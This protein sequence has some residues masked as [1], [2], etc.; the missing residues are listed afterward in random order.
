M[1][2]DLNRR[3]LLAG[4]ALLPATFSAG[5]PNTGPCEADLGFDRL[6]RPTVR[7]ADSGRWTLAER[8][9]HHH[10]PA[11]AVAILRDGRLHHVRGLGRLAAGASAAA[12]PSTLFSV[13][14]VSKVATAA[15]CLRLVSLGHLDL[16]RD[17]G[18][19]LRRW[20]L[21]PG[22]AGDDAPVTIRMLLSHTAGLNVHGFA[23]FPPGAELPTL[24]Q[25]LAGA[26]PARNRPIA[27]IGRA[28]ER[29]RYSGG[30]YMVVQAVLEDAMGLAFERLAAD[31]LFAPLGMARSF[32]SAA[33]SADQGDIARAHDREGNPAAL[34][35]GW[36]S[37]PELAAS[38]LW[39]CALDLARLIAALTGSHRG[40]ANAFLPRSLAMEMMIPV[41]PGTFGLGPRLA[42]HGESAIFH[43]GGANDSY[44]GWI[45]GH[46]AS[47]DGLA[48]L[49]N[50]ANGDV[51]GDE[52]RNAVSDAMGWPG[53]WSVIAQ[54]A[55]GND[56]LPAYAGR[57]A[58]RPDQPLELAGALDAA[59]DHASIGIET[60]EGGLVLVAGERRLGLAPLTGSRFVMPDF[61]IPADTLQLEFKRAAD[62]SV[63]GLLVLG[64]GGILLFDRARDS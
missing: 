59:F 29:A 40:F 50:G 33:L 10:V 12:G 43:H 15:L 56:F 25:I 8:M 54:A 41:S 51:L 57:Y 44:K 28:G 6:L 61:Y 34:P 35:R 53:D 36:Q 37:F 4:A 48:I 7:T 32:F 45:E 22:P 58:R 18:R 49:T 1:P 42:G 26:A 39:T 38:G 11:V 3:H 16:D 31:H 17:V 23:D 46:L 24:G 47:G 55:N 14:S 64:G 63:D 27:R 62:R 52:I 13:G 5:T 60:R 2:I 19:W 30:G 9:A 20:R 21:P